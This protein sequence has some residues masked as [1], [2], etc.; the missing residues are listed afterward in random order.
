MIP[1]PERD[2][3]LY[4]VDPAPL[5]HPPRVRILFPF[6]VAFF[7]LVSCAGHWTLVERG[8]HSRIVRMAPQA[9]IIRSSE[10]RVL[11]ESEG[12][13]STL[14]LLGFMPVTKPLNMEYAI[15]QAIQ[16]FPEGQSMVDMVYWHET[17]YY[18][19]LAIVSVL[20]VHGTVVSLRREP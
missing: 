17:H 1:Q 13:S 2:K 15:S 12:E 7:F 3:I 9:T 20:K 11:G 6:L 4:P 10:Y 16:K 18:Y 14:F 5:F 19:P 8:G